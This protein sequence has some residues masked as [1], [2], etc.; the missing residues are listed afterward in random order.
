MVKDTD[1]SSSSIPR[2]SAASAS[3]TTGQP[4]TGAPGVAPATPGA[5]LVQGPPVAHAAGVPT[6]APSAEAGSARP[7]PPASPRETTA[8][9]TG[10]P[11]RGRTP[12]IPTQRVPPADELAPTTPRRRKVPIAV[13][14]A[15][16]F[17]L[18]ATGSATWGIQRDRAQAAEEARQ[19]AHSRVD[20]VVAAQGAD[21]AASRTVGEHA[22]LVVYD[23]GRAQVQ[24]AAQAALAHAAA[25]LAATPQAGDGPRAALQGASDALTT[26]AADPHVSFAALRT[27][28]AGLAAPDQAAVQAQAA[29]QAAEDARIAAEQAAAAQAAADAAARAAAK[30]AKARTTTRSRTSTSS[31]STTAPE[32]ETSGGA[33]TVYP[34]D[35]IGAALNSFRSSQGLGTLAIV[36]SGARVSHARAMAASDSIY[37]S[38]AT[39]EIVGRVSGPSS[40]AMINAYA[41]SASHRAIMVGNY[42]TAYIGA[43]T[44]PCSMGGNSYGECLYTAITFG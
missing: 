13:A 37:H 41:N 6:P 11:A 34:A 23:A 14:G 10:A 32:P 7:A 22:T 25:T 44:A 18:V 26:A 2:R 29:W 16:A 39:P 3:A 1:R 40:S 12:T 9:S 33:G 21:A 17:A 4:T 35:S 42:S 15:V 5:T 27:A 38:G 20:E 30:P 36:S 28:T 31:S 24:S 19:Q 43:V 8:P